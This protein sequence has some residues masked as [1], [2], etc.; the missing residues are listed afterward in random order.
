MMAT[1]YAP[2]RTEGTAALHDP[3]RTGWPERGTLWSTLTDICKLLRVDVDVRDEAAEMLFQ[4]RHI[5]PGQHVYRAGQS[6]ESLYIVHSGFLKTV[7]LDGEGN[8]RVLAFP[9]KGDLLGSDGIYKDRH[10]SEVTAL[11]DCDVVVVPFRQLLA[12]SHSCSAFEQVI[13]RVVSREIVQEHANAAALAALHSDARVARFLALQSQRHA[14]LGFSP[15][16]FRL[17]M[18]RREIGSYLGLTLETVSRGMSALAAAGVITVN[19]REIEILQPD[20]LSS[21]QKS[22]GACADRTRIS[23]TTGAAVTSS[24]TR[25][26]TVA[27][28]RNEAALAV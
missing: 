11:S 8:E 9:M 23:S 28:N 27:R 24:T 14:A 22:P 18:T 21:M 20:T 5:K 15:R 12:L 13:Y 4:H 16:A 17:R 19:Q 10:A 6:F 25:G 1:A 3:A 7:M 2:T 26:S